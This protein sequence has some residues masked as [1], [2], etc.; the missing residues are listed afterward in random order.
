MPLNRLTQRARYLITQLPD[1]YEVKTADVIVLLSR[2]AGLAGLLLKNFPDVKIKKGQI[3]EVNKLVTEAYYQSSKMEHP[4]VGTEH[5]LLALLAVTG[6]SD[7]QKVKEHLLSI[8]IFPKALKVL[9]TEKKESMVLDAFGE[10][11]SR[12]LYRLYKEPL[13]DRKEVDQLISVLLKRENSNALIIG[14]MGVG[15]RSLVQLLVR[16]IASLDVPP[17]LAGHRV[18]EFDIMSYLS[19]LATKGN[20]ELTLMQLQDELR[21]MNRV[22]LSIKNFESLFIP[23]GAGVGIPTILP[24]L[25]DAL[26]SSGV[27]IIA[28]ISSSIY[29]RITSDNDHIFQNFTVIEVPEPGDEKTLEILNIKARALEEFHNIKL[30]DDVIEYVYDSALEHMHNMKFPQ[31][32][33][34]LL[35]AAC[36]HMLVRKSKVPE[37]YKDLVD[38]T[39]T[40]FEA[41]DKSLSAGNYEE[42]VVQQ[43]RIKEYERKLNDYEDKMITSSPLALTKADVDETLKEMNLTKMP[44]EEVDTQLLSDLAQTIKKEIIGQDEAVDSVAKALI[45]SKLG[46]RPKKRPIGSFLFLGPTGVGKTELA[47]ILSQYAFGSAG[48]N[49]LI[50][51]DMSDFSEKHT[52]ARLVGAPPGYVGYNEGGELTQKIDLQPNSVVLFDEIEKAHPDVLNILLQIMEEGELADAKGHAYDFSRAVVILTSNLGTEILHNQEIGFTEGVNTAE[53]ADVERNLKQNLKKILKP[54][55]LNR[56]DEVIVFRRLTEQDQ[57]KILDLLLKEVD[58][59]LKDQ[60]VSLRLNRSAKEYLLKLGYSKEYGARSLRRVVEKELLD[61]VAE[62]LLAN[63]A[64]PLKL[65][66]V[67]KEGSLKV[68][69]L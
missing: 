62:V 51:L 13:I 4:Y 56:F 19:S 68:K 65:S 63:T 43:D 11:L 55:L 32:G 48:F 12:N 3:V 9:N 22:I 35:D 7:Y 40:M 39:M 60:Q 23:T 5:L 50:R 25:K 29:D 14:D 64:R 34:N 44:D 26:E 30:E 31:K 66:V 6:S 1:E 42:A 53:D 2:S 49:H 54:E 16:D 52:V 67:G 17:H 10:D 20:I 45:R 33:I 27:N 58:K 38:R 21:G 47:K 46:L 59:N 36:A 8:N 41:I 15:K 24:S 18:I 69:V 28:T 37:G 61:A 57:V